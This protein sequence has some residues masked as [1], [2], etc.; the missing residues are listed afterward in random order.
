MKSNQD[1]GKHHSVKG[2]N[3]FLSPMWKVKVHGYHIPKNFVKQLDI[4][5]FLIGGA[6]NIEHASMEIAIKYCIVFLESI[7]HLPVFLQDNFTIFLSQF[8]NNKITRYVLNLFF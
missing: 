3:H 6:L 2:I 4:Q 1:Q 5:L 7:D 8:I